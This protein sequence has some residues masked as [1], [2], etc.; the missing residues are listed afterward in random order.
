MTLFLTN[1][2][3]LNLN[4]IIHLLILEKNENLIFTFLE[5]LKNLILEG[6][7][8]PNIEYNHN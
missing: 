3:N 4:N 8:S 6:I 2:E 7:F 5:I 1:L